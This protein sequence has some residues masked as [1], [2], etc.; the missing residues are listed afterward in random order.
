MPMHQAPRSPTRRSTSGWPGR[1]AR[2]AVARRDGE[3]LP[4]RRARVGHGV[5]GRSR[6]RRRQRARR[7][8]PTW[9]ATP[10]S[11]AL[12]GGRLQ[13]DHARGRRRRGA[14]RAR[15][16]RGGRPA[17]ARQAPRRAHRDAD[18]RGPAALR[19][20]RRRGIDAAATHGGHGR[21]GHAEPVAR[22]LSDGRLE[23]GFR[24]RDLVESGAALPLGSDWMVADY[25]PR[26]GMAWARLR[27]TPGR[28][29]H[30]PFLPEQ[31]L[32]ASRPCTDTRRAPAAVAG[33][34]R[35]LRAAAGR[36]ARRHH[37]VRRRSL[38]RDPD[39]LPE[40]PVELT[41][42]DGEIV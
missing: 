38:R 15:R 17:A 37:R 41:V 20:A 34:E 35:G 31:A 16:L 3:V 12:H 42:V 14:R 40:L 36:A 6:P 23:R 18:R 25:D 22:R 32:D 1:R 33:D 13:R 9:G 27:R 4:R 39:E 21:T 19:R 11:C 30:V 28:P 24:T 10:S 26:V 5:A 29:D 2:A 8:G 7:S